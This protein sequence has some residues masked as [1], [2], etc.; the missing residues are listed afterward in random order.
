MSE[1]WVFGI[2]IEGLEGS[3]DEGL[4]PVLLTDRNDFKC[5]RNS[6]TA[7]LTTSTQQAELDVLMGVHFVVLC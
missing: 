1:G 2:L 7:A 6:A 4:L 3:E 5:N